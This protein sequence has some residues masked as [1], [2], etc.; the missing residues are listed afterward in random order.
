VVAA[1]L[2]YFVVRVQ[3]GRSLR[4]V[5]LVLFPLVFVLFSLDEVAR[6]HEGIGGVLDRAFLD[7]PRTETVLGKTG[8]WFVLFGIPFVVVFAAL[9]AIVMPY[10]RRAPGAFVRI[11]GGL[12]LFFIGAVGI[13]A[14]SNIVVRGSAFDAIQ[15][16]VEEAF[17]LVSST[18]VLWGAYLLARRTGLDLD[19]ADT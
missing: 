17:E 16:I 7:Q 5:A 19:A 1:L 13:E 2:W 6:I 14:L 12:A 8:V 15:V 11:G 4:K 3:E 10:L 18:A 9:V